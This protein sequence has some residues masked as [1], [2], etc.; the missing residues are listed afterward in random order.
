MKDASGWRYVAVTMCVLQA[1]TAGFLVYFGWAYAD[2]LSALKEAGDFCWPAGSA[3]DDSIRAA[4]MFGRLDVLTLVF[5]LVAV[6][7]GVF[8]LVGFGVFRREVIGQ[9]RDVVAELVPDE[10]RRVYADNYK[11]PTSREGSGQLF[12]PSD[13]PYDKVAPEEE[14]NEVAGSASD[15]QGAPNA[16][17]SASGEDRPGPWYRRLFD[18]LLGR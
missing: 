14:P 10:V 5:A 8:A 2:N 11:Q 9:A 12:T 18:A 15:N 16:S 13:V 7:L 6:T 1:I 17:A 4:Q 3:E